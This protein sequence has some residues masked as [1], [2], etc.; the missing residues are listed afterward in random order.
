MKKERKS[1]VF[2][3]ILMVAAAFLWAQAAMGGD[4]AGPYFWGNGDCDGILSPYDMT[5]MIIVINGGTFPGSG[6][7]PNHSSILDLDGSGT[8]D[9]LDERILRDWL[10]AKSMWNDSS[11]QYEYASAHGM[12]HSIELTDPASP[13]ISVGTSL[14]LQAQVLSDSEVYGGQARPRAG[15]GIIYEI[16]SDPVCSGATVFTLYGRSVSSGDNY[17]DYNRA[18]DYTSAVNGPSDYDGGTVHVKLK[19]P[20]DSSC[21]GKEVRVSVR[22]PSESE[23][24]LN[25]KRF[26]EPLYADEEFALWVG[27]NVIYVNA[28]CSSSCN[29]SSWATGYDVIQ[30]AVDAASGNDAIFVKIGTYLEGSTAPSSPVLAMADNVHLFGGFAGTE[31]QL[32]QRKNPLIQRTVLDGEDTKYHVVTGASNA[33]LDGFVILDGKANGGVSSLKRGAGLV[34]DGESNLEVANC[35]FEYNTATEYGAAIYLSSGSTIVID[36]CIFTENQASINGGA[37]YITDGSGITVS[38]SRFNSIYSATYNNQAMNGHGGA[39]YTTGGT[40]PEIVNCEFSNNKS[41]DDGGAVYAH[42]GNT[43]VISNSIFR[44]NI[45]SD[46]G[47]AIYISNTNLLITN[48]LFDDNSAVYYGGAIENYDQYGNYEATIIN[49]TFY[50]NMAWYYGCA[51][52]LQSGSSLTVRNSIIWDSCTD[53]EEVYG[54]ASSTC[55]ISYTDVYSGCPTGCSCS[56]NLNTDPDFAQGICNIEKFYLTQ[57][58]NSLINGGDASASSLGLDDRT[59]STEC[60]AERESCPLDSATVDLGYHYDTDKCGG[61]CDVWP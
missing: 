33:T 3:A 21:A 55:S 10:N 19:I 53:P 57:S 61:D 11:N 15:W 22:A 28:D 46:N 54:G 60:A 20:N 1:W 17:G 58:G 9:L 4:M 16:E 30:D 18:Y 14:N 23:A 12:P 42:D 47:G 50:Q 38:N 43:L 56:N 5:S 27:G 34:A 52:N 32:G 51:V 8:V 7:H 36:R 2:L 24:G 45:A 25:T 29:G 26:I 44:D 37:I 59:T 41:G 6:C 13:S 39:I 48:A 49:S 31:A 35:T 40:S